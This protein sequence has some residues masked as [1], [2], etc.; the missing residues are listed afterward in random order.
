MDNKI[1]KIME[2]ISIVSGKDKSLINVSI[3]INESGVDSIAF[4]ELV[5]KIEQEFDVEIDDEDS[6]ITNY[7]TIGDLLKVVEKKLSIG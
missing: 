1:D 5:V 2:I 3:P 4:I 6:D 7:N